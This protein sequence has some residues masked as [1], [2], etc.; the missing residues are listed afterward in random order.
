MNAT[1]SLVSIQGSQIQVE[2][3][4]VA[5]AKLALK[6]LK[7]KKKEVQA[8]RKEVVAQQQAIRAA[9]TDR[10]RSQGSMVRG[11]GWVG[12]LV[13]AGQATARD[14]AKRQ[15][16]ND[17]RPLDVEKARL[18]GAIIAFDKVILEVETYI[19]ENS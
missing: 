3:T 17:L 9:Y 11:G 5:E 1:R 10:V 13:R 19:H 6:E 18:D 4:T 15:L 16:A 8:Q 7:L 14:S 12:K 2:V